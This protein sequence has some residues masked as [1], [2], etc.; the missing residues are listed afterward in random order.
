MIH[1]GNRISEYVTQILY[2]SRL[3]AS[4]RDL[5]FERISLGACC[6]EILERYETVLAEEGIQVSLEVEDAWVVTDRKG[7]LFILEQGMSNACKYQDGSKP[8]E[9]L[10]I[11]G[12]IDGDTDE[13]KERATGMGLYL[14]GEMAHHLNIEIT[15]ESEYGQG[16]TLCLAFPVVEG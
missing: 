12:G 7:L 15:A 2:Y 9:R 8:E 3:K 16:F 6:E 10:E 14:A 4:H 13:K 1:A 5:R 11:S